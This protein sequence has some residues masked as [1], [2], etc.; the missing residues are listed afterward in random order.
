M[1]STIKLQSW[2]KRQ[3][4]NLL[5]LPCCNSAVVFAFCTSYTPSNLARGVW[6]AQRTLFSLH[7]R[8]LRCRGA[9]FLF[10]LCVTFLV[11]TFYS[12]PLTHLICT[13]FSFGKEKECCLFIFTDV[14]EGLYAA[15]DVSLMYALC[16]CAP[17]FFYQVYS[18]LMPSC[19][20]G[21]RVTVNLFLF[22]A[23]VLFFIILY[24]AFFFLL[25]KICTFLQ[26]FQYSSK[27]M[28]IKLEARI[29]PA[30]RWCCT[31]FLFTAF[32]FQMPVLLALLLN[33][34]VI[35]WQ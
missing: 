12:S 18:F 33:W 22:S 19:Y 8:E 14:T 2:K 28:E 13:P 20:Q 15:V 3:A 16:F 35:R 4:K 29:A 25:P 24:T 11:G 21:E 31:A 5:V 27:C 17:L 23:A 26:Q 6:G 30:V 32:F 34:G 1:L 10:S 9:Y 7:F